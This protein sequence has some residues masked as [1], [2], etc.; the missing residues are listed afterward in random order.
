MFKSFFEENAYRNAYSKVACKGFNTTL[1]KFV[2]SF[3]LEI[4]L[5][6]VVIVSMIY[7]PSCALRVPC[8]DVAMLFVSHDLDNYKLNCFQ[9]TNECV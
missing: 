5:C 9:N 3:R 4:V 6:V 2:R 8:F 1:E 7:L